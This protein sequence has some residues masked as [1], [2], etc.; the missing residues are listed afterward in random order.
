M[1]FL[2]P[3]LLLAGLG[4]SLPILAHLL[5]RYRVQHTPW[6]AMQFLNRSVRVRSRQLRLKDILLLCLRCLAVLLLGLALAKPVMNDAGGEHMTSQSLP[7]G[8]E[9]HATA[10]AFRRVLPSPFDNTTFYRYRLIYKGSA[11]FD[12]AY[13]A[14][15]VDPDLGYFGDDYVGVVMVEGEIAS[16]ELYDY[17]R[18]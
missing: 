3:L 13:V 5:N 11:P 9:V 18:S 8:M 15:F 10:F 1:T 12:E 6:A 2:H 4:V 16:L 14:L 7:I 17:E